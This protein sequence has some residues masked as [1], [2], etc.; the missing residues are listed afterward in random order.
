MTGFFVTAAGTE[1]GKTFVTRALLHQLRAVGRACHALKPIVSGFED[2]GL[3]DPALLLAAMGE[4][5]TAERIATIAPWRYAEPLSPDMAA[6]RSGRPIDFAELVSFCLRPEPRGLRL[7]EGVGGVMAPLTGTHTV[8][9][10]MVALRL[11]AVLVVGSYLGT[12]SHALTAAA[13]LAA[14]DIPIAGIVVN[15]SAIEPVPTAESAATLARFLPGIRIV[16]LPRLPTPESPL[17]PDLLP[18][19]E[20]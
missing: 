17:V 4:H 2:D 12:L 20:C 1:I 15:Q 18:L 3:S 9:D 14:V 10:W 6:A 7:I 13:A 5:A 19:L 8:R 16:V 11:P